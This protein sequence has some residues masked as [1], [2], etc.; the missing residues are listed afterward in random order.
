MAEPFHGGKLRIIGTASLERRSALASSRIPL[1]AAR[2]YATTVASR[3]SARTPEDALD[4]L[5][6]VAH[7]FVVVKIC[8][9]TVR[10]AFVHWMKIAL[11]SPVYP[12]RRLARPL[13]MGRDD[14]ARI[15]GA[16]GQKAAGWAAEAIC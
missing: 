3:E 6:S 15:G 1:R 9:L 12:C 8:P 13:R 11:Y 16:Q 4:I 10:P 7:V 5:I 2:H 14:A